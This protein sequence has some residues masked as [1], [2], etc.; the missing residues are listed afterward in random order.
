MSAHPR[1]GIRILNIRRAMGGK[2]PQKRKQLQN[3]RRP[4][5]MKR[6]FALNALGGSEESYLKSLMGS[7]EAY[8]KKFMTSK[9]DN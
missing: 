5:E 1:G 9:G 8:L 6:K 4:L 2:S 3:M 7:E